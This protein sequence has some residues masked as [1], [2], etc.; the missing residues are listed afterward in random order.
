MWQY[1]ELGLSVALAPQN[2]LW[3]FLG[4][5]YGTFVGVLPGFGPSA[6]IALLLPITFKM[7]TEGAIIMLAGLYY[8][9]AYGGSTTSI[10]VNIPGE[11]ASIVTTFDGYQMAKQ[12]RAGPALGISAIGSFIA[13]I[14]TVSA[15]CIIAPML[16]NFAL[17]FG[18]PEFFSVMVLGLTLVVYISFG[19]VPK[20]LIMGGFGIVL[21]C[22]GWD[23]IVG[24]TRL[25]FGV[26]YLHDG[27]P[28]VPMV[29]G[30]FGIS[31]VLINIEKT[32][33]LEIFREVKN[34]WPSLRDLR[35]SIFPIFRGTGTGFLLGLIP[36]CG[37]LVS[38]FAA[39]IV[40]KRISKNPQEFGRGAIQ[41]VASPESANNAAAQSGFIPLLTLGIPVSPA[42]VMVFA[43][44]LIHG[45]TPG[46]L[47][48]IRTPNIF[49]G[50]ISSMLV[51]NFMLVILNLPLIRM[52]VK[53]L[54]IPYS[55]LFP[56]IL[57]FCLIGAL[58]DYRL[59]SVFV[60]I[61]FGVMGY[62]MK[63]LTYEPAPLI[64]AFILSPI[65]ELNFRQAMILSGGSFS[66]FFTK[67]ISLFSLVGVGAL[68]LFAIV[69][70]LRVMW[71]KAGAE[72]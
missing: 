65:L 48:L 21:G 14:L 3:C 60:M 53:I 40:E 52:W 25:T 43:A 70:K 10:L 27:L 13:G 68:F 9:A 8:G 15:L 31:E 11:A 69:S 6:A 34:I 63:K 37:T 20:A 54:D 56:L 58:S 17:K 23:Y 42:F 12:G 36:G 38:T 33:K 39:Y 5:V 46:P 45:V 59:G 51:A 55:L 4:C 62:L 30:L 2:L 32:Q 28:V 19:S 41:G 66:I 47:V 29:M 18:P 49:W 24:A 57:I 7:P 71:Q 64:I 67:P 44:L 35:K 26:G 72:G 61:I 22:V 1:L 16:A 50:V